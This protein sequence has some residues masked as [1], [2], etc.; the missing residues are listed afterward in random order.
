[1]RDNTIIDKLARTIAR[2]EL[3]D[4]IN[5]LPFVYADADIQNIVLDTIQPPFAAIIPLSSGLVETEHGQYNER[6]TIAVWFGDVMCQPMTDYDAVEN[7]RI[8]DGC[9]H[10]AF[11]W[12]AS[13]APSPASELRLV[14]VNAAERA[15]LERDSCFTGYIVSVTIDELESVGQC[16]W[17]ALQTT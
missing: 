4:G 14:S 6:A 8:I 2:K 5:A 17:R 7:E 9:K 11:L 12:L 13:L 3:N 15:Y 16:Q 10:R 1:M